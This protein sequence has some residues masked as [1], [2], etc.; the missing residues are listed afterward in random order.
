MA[1]PVFDVFGHP[2]RGFR[3]DA[4]VG[5]IRTSAYREVGCRALT[6][7]LEP[8]IGLAATEL[9]NAAC[10]EAKEER[11]DDGDR[12]SDG[13]NRVSAT[14]LVFEGRLKSCPRGSGHALSR[15]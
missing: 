13:Q 8:I 10:S 5:G 2:L 15:R 11:E 6:S 1:E 12:G 3:F 9:E 7:C 14:L 4:Q